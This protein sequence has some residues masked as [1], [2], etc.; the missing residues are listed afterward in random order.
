MLDGKRSCLYFDLL[1]NIV[2]LLGKNPLESE[3]GLGT[4]AVRAFVECL[5][6]LIWFCDK[7]DWNSVKMG[8]E[9]LVKFAMGKRPK[10]VSLILSACIYL[11][12]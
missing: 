7:E 8:F 2:G 9:L 10:V 11:C 1:W 4:S 5:G 3:S 6:I 12:L